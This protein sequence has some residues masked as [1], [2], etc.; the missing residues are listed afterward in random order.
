MTPTSPAETKQPSEE[1]KNL[2]ANPALQ[3]MPE[4]MVIRAVH[5]EMSDLCCPVSGC[6]Y[7]IP[8]WGGQY[9]CQQHWSGDPQAG[10]E[11]LRG[12]RVLKIAPHTG[13]K[14]SDQKIARAYDKA[15]EEIVRLEAEIERLKTERTVSGVAAFELHDD[16]RAELERLTQERNSFQA[17]LVTV[18]EDNEQLKAKLRALEKK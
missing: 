17:G 1:E 11:Y 15:M 4:L 14:M 9:P 2:A 10:R 13:A 6:G 12:C 3:L 18:V 7:G 5:S 8:S 16:L